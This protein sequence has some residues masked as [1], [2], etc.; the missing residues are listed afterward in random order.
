L[1][2]AIRTAE[3]GQALTELALV[4]PLF[5]SVLLI[6]AFLAHLMLLRLALIQLTRDTALM[7]ARDADHWLASPTQQ[8]EQMRELAKQY[9]VFVPRYLSLQVEATP[10]PGG[11]NLGAGYFGRLF[12]G[13]KIQLQ[14]TYHT[15]G[16][17]HQF[18]P[19]DM[20]L[21]EWVVA[22]GDPWCNPGET[23]AKAFIGD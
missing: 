11:M 20:V 17:L 22:Q 8:Q 12:A 6:F 19:E 4:G 18:W 2:A 14:Y 3:S 16:L 7:L 10:L 5:A 15:K 9:P 21:S 1:K 23:L 13:A